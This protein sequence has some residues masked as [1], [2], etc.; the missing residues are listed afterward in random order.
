LK[1]KWYKIISL[2]G[3]LLLILNLL[4]SGFHQLEPEGKVE[5]MHW[6]LKVGILKF[7]EGHVDIGND[8]F[9]H[10]TLIQAKASSTGLLLVIYKAR[11]YFGATIGPNTGLPIQATRHVT[12]GKYEIYNV[13]DLL[14]PISSRFVCY[15]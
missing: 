13:G 9:S 15:P 6:E 12:E 7:G 11:Y 3:I 14:S 5:S 4:F 8:P 1:Y 10:H 2:A